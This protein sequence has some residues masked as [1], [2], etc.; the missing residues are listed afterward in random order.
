MDIGGKDHDRRKQP[1]RRHDDVGLVG[2]PTGGLL[3]V[4]PAP[5]HGQYAEH[6]GLGGSDARGTDS[7]ILA[8]AQRGIEEAT[9]HGDT[10]VLN[11]GALWILF[12]I[13][14]VFRQ[15]LRHE[16]LSLFLL[17]MGE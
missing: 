10:P 3:P 11:L 9:Y 8:V 5:L 6:D 4:L 13:D 1:T 14:E 17:D 16:L 12:V 2:G 7:A 15:G